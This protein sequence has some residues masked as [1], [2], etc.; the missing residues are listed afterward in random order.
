M[1]GQREFDR[2]R[3]HINVLNRTIHT[4]IAWRQEV[5]RDLALLKWVNDMPVVDPSR[6]ENV[7]SEAR[8]IAIQ[9]KG[10]PEFAARVARLLIEH[11][12]E[13]QQAEI[14][15][16]ENEGVS[17]SISRLGVLRQVS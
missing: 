8:R 1:K 3:E 16:F 6:E 2:N 14:V 17:R 11:S 7:E 15:R 10:D 13:V 12:V 4:T 9:E 5:Y